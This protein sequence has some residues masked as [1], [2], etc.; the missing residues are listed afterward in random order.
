VFADLIAT[1]RSL[2]AV[3]ELVLAGPQYRAHGDIRL[4]VRPQG[5][6][7]VVGPDVRVAV[8]SVVRD[9]VIAPI[10]GASPATIA[11]ELGLSASA[12]ADVYSGGSGVALDEVLTADPDHADYLAGCFAAGD[13]ALARFAPQAERVLWPEHFD[14]GIRVDNVNYGI[15]PGDS[16]SPTPYA[17]VGPGEHGGDAFWNAPF[18]AALALGA[19]PDADAIVAFFDE[20]RSLAVG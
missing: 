19:E 8:A 6:S 10:D 14:V 9:D 7:T 3:A 16:F 1:R 15:S 11:K 18:G 20:G 13:D 12:L 4:R 2:H 5:F 17:Y